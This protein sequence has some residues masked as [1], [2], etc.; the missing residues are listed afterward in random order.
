MNFWNEPIEFLARQP[1][2]VERLAPVY[3]A[4][5]ESM[6]GNFYVPEKLCEQARSLG[7]MPVGLRGSVNRPLEVKPP[8]SAAPMVTCGYHDLLTSVR[9]HAR[10]PQI[11]VQDN[12]F[13][14]AAHQKVSLFICPSEERHAWVIKHWASKPAEVC[15]TADRMAEVISGFVRERSNLRTVQEINGESIGI[16]YMAFGLKSAMAV[17]TSYKSLRRVGLQI[18]ACVIGS[19]PAEG[20]PFI[21]WRGESPFDAGQRHNFQFRAGRI[22]PKLYDLTPFERTLYIDADTEFMGDILPGFE[23]LSECDAAIARENLTL[24]QLYNKKLAGWEINLVERDA[25][26]QELQAGENVFF[27]NSGVLFFRKC[28]AVEAAMGRWHE[29]WMRWQQWD[30]QLAFMRAFYKTPEARVKVLEPEWN[31]PHRKEGV[32]VFHNYGRAVVRMDVATPSLTPI[33]PPFPHLST[34]GER[35][36]VELMA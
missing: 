16:V 21:E 26:I 24:K 25:T 36:P 35:E 28:A 15:E 1:Q 5:D 27:L 6:R 34:D 4:M 8:A 19:T 33:P 20:L 22:K 30:E 17:G 11:Y 9:L 10:R 31:Y 29:E 3:L 12:E 14:A 13:K 2:Y 32:F 18:P 23:A 7:V